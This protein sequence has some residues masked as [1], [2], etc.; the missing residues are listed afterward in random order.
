MRTGVVFCVNTDTETALE[1]FYR[2]IRSVKNKQIELFD[3]AHS[4]DFRKPV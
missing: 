3:N 1:I 2:K 4:I